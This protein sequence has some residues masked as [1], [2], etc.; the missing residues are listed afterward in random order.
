[1]SIEPD[2]MQPVNGSDAAAPKQFR[3]GDVVVA[4]ETRQMAYFVSGV[5]Q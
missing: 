2:E 3:P 4:V 5:N 1:M